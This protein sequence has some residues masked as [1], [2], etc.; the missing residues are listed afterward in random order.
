MSDNI[1]QIKDLQSTLAQ[2]LD[3]QNNR[4]PDQGNTLILLSLVNL[5]GILNIL[6]KKIEGTA[7]VSAAGSPPVDLG[8]LQQLI[9]PVMSMMA[10]QGEAGGGAKSA[11]SNNQNPLG[12]LMNM[13]GGA[14]GLAN[15]APLLSLLGGGGQ[16]SQNMDLASLMKMFNGLMAANPPGSAA[17][18][19]TATENK[20][21]ASKEDMS[22]QEEDRH[23]K[24]QIIV[25][26]RVEPKKQPPG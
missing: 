18:N 1:D 7:S 2:L 26:K 8:S 13:L 11:I 14:N 5:M 10:K 12:G 20:S 21:A 22:P 17:P 3:F 6:N 25:E 19:N 4:G 15:L 23:D 24:N 9:G 16:G